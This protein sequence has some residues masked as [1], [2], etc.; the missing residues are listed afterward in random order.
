MGKVVRDDLI[1]LLP[2]IAEAN[3]ISQ[4]LDKSVHFDLVVKT[5]ASH[6]LT[7]KSK[8]VFVK[9]TDR[10]TKYVWLWPKSKFINRKY[11]MQELYELWVDGE[12]IETDQSKDPFW[13][14]PEDLFLGSVYLYLQSLAYQLDIDDSLTV[15]NYQGQDEGKLHVGLCPCDATGRPLAESATSF[16]SSPQ[17]LLQKRMDLLVRIPYARNIKWVQEDASRGISCRFKFYTD[18]KMRYTKTI[19]HEVNPNF[20]YTKQFTIKSVSHNFI[21]Y[22][23]HN[24]LVIEVWGKQG[25]GHSSGS[26]LPMPMG[27][28]GTRNANDEASMDH[29]LSETQWR[30]ERV[31]LLQQ[32]E[33]LTKEVDFLRIEKGVLEKE[34]TRITLASET[35]MQGADG[36]LPGDGPGQELPG[37]VQSFLR[38]D[39]ILRERLDELSQYENRP[40]KPEMKS[41]K[42]AL[43]NQDKQVHVV[44]KE[45]NTMVK[46]ARQVTEAIAKKPQA[47]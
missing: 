2:M 5:G 21:N 38:E 9:V 10:S 41:L 31:Q 32:L 39:H 24:A 44:L 1:A 25:T 34:M 45:L 23:E 13:D 30:T 29:V 17:E 3:A 8:A 12:A 33:D 15:T 16:V 42:Q 27:P 19:L 4:E 43:E 35:F 14:P 28:A 22:L 47:K 26:L 37:M 46:A 40:S 18:T 36:M 7:D 6:N 20:D 11:L